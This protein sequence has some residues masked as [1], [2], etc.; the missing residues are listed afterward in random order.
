MNGLINGFDGVGKELCKEYGLEVPVYG[1]CSAKADSKIYNIIYLIYSTLQ[2][3]YI[4]LVQSMHQLNK[5]KEF[6]LI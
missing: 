1:F 3:Q 6:D 2:N 4:E 5:N